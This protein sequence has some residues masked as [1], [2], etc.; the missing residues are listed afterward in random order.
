M[1]SSHGSCTDVWPVFLLAAGCWRKAYGCRCSGSRGKLHNCFYLTS[2][3][4]M[5]SILM[6]DLHDRCKS[7]I[8]QVRHA[9][10]RLEKV[11]LE[12]ESSL[13]ERFEKELAEKEKQREKEVKELQDLLEQE[14]TAKHTKLDSEDDGKL[15]S[16]EVHS[17][18]KMEE[19]E[20]ERNLWYTRGVMDSKVLKTESQTRL[21]VSID[22]VTCGHWLTA[23]SVWAEEQ[24]QVK[25]LK[26]QWLSQIVKTWLFL[27]VFYNLDPWEDSR[28]RLEKL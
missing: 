26:A 3:V 19:K 21:H 7:C 17:E 25:I 11:H 14:R 5:A 2:D 1:Y 16:L 9:E 18:E 20:K 15:V 22:F 4:C 6:V 24:E 13:Q 27:A 23:I 8:Q 10:E 28:A 12:H